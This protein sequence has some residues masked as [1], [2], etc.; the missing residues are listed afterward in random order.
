MLAVSGVGSCAKV[1]L[2]SLS[3]S[4]KEHDVLCLGCRPCSNEFCQVRILL[5]LHQ[6]YTVETKNSEE[7]N[8]RSAGPHQMGRKVGHITGIALGIVQLVLTLCYQHWGLPAGHSCFSPH[9][10]LPS[11]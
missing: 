7:T 10:Y 8:S 3:Q 6:S 2:G 4:R 9:M 11:T 1:L 5:V